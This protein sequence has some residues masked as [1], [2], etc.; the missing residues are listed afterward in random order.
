MA[1]S[2]YESVIFMATREAE[3]ADKLFGVLCSA[4]PA[5]GE[6]AIRYR[7]AGPD[8]ILVQRGNGKHV[9]FGKA[10]NGRYRFYKI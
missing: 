2:F 6:H 3:E 9:F 4:W 8:L 1:L 7:Y 10:A 5:V